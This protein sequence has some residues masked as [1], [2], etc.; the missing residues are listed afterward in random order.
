MTHVPEL[1]DGARVLVVADLSGATPTLATRHVVSGRERSGF[2]GLA[3]ARYDGADG[4]YLFYCDEEWNAVTDTC[5]DTME[6]ALSQA[7]FEF[8]TVVFVDAA[9]A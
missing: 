5:H 9:N 3:I 4:L 1:I 8:G 7:Q 6:Q 2:A